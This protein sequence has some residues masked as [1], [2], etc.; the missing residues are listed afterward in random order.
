MATQVL[1]VHP[2]GELSG[3]AHEGESWAAAARRVG[4]SLTGVP[5]AR[6]LSG[7][8]KVFQI[9]HDLVVSVRAMTRGD[10]PD[11]TRWR[12]APH[13]RRWW[14]GDGP[15]TPEE[16]AARYGA[17]IDGASPTRMWVAEVNGRAVGFLQDYRIADYP[18][19]ALLGP[20]PTAIGVDYAVGEPAWL[21]RGIGTRVLW[22][23]MERA[24]HRFPTAPAFF[25][26]PDHRNATSLRVLD[27]V[28]FSRGLWFDETESDGT[29]STVVGCR[30]DVGRVLA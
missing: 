26:A 11:L 12:Q 5:V 7:V 16:V 25:A 8:A 24:H 10:L 17:R 28:G 13:V 20:D 18:E 19:Y 15:P 30:L 29:V 4:A 3:V 23:W 21:G 1:V 6:D 27:K 2:G 9:D 22:A 14:H